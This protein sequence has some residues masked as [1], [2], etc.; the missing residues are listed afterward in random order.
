MDLINKIRCDWFSKDPIYIE[1]H[2][3]EWGVTVYDDKKLFE[4]LLLETF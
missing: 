4:I 2:D 3:K 1:Y